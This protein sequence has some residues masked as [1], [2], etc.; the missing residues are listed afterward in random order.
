MTGS[1]LAG[2]AGAR[3][4]L[5]RMLFPPKPNSRESD[6]TPPDHWGGRTK[7]V[8]FHISTG[9][10]IGHSAVAELRDREI[11]YRCED[12]RLRVRSKQKIPMRTGHSTGYG[13][14]TDD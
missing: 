3:A 14:K 10:D 5:V 11:R 8:I 2:T 9:T 13:N 6:N 1:S 4:R 7:Q 12:R